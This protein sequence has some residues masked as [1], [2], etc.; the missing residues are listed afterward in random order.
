MWLGQVMASKSQSKNRPMLSAFL[1]S[2]CE[3]YIAIR[4]LVLY[5]GLSWS[6][7]Y[8]RIPFTLGDLSTFCVVWVFFVCVSVPGVV[9]TFSFRWCQQDLSAL[10]WANPGTSAAPHKSCPSDQS[11]SLQPS[12]GCSLAVNRP[13]GQVASHQHGL[14]SVGGSQVEAAGRAWGDAKQAGPSANSVWNSRV[15]PAHFMVLICNQFNQFTEPLW[16]SQLLAG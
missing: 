11:P 8:L 2:Y 6:G 5:K 10:G 4:A 15:S 7:F 3:L 14:R 16:N 13:A 1:G 9:G 12:F